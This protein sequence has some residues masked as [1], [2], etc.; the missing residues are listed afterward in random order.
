M[1]SSDSLD[2]MGF[3]LDFTELKA[4]VGKWVDLHWDHGF[5]INDRDQELLIALE[6]LQRSK[7]FEFHDENPT[8]EVIAKHLFNELRGQYG[9]LVSKVRIWESPNQYAEYFASGS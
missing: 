9:S 5:L 6:S 2:E 1:V 4:S 3:I 8:A 7:I